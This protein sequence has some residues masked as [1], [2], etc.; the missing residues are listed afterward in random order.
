L[1]CFELDSPLSVYGGEA[2]IAD[3]KVIGM[4]TS[5]DFGHTV[6]RML[7]LGYVPNEHFGRAKIEIEAF[8]QR[9]VAT[10]VERCAYDPANERIRA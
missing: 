1:E 10:R 3:G 8:G 5:G 2:M 6:G 4:T 7:V 9:S